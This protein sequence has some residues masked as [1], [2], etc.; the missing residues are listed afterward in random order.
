MLV[1]EMLSEVRDHGFDDL[2]DTRI[3]GFINDTYW[4][5]CSREAWPFLE[6]SAAVTVDATGKITSPASIDK[7]LAISTTSPN[8]PNLIPMRT[9]EFTRTYGTNLSLAGTPQLYYSEGDDFFVYPIPASAQLTIRYIRIP[10]ALTVSPDS[11]P[12]LPIQH[13]RAVVLGTLVK[14]YTLEDDPEQA[15]VFTNMYEQRLVQMR[16]S[17][18]MRQY[19][20]T[21]TIQDLETD[22]ADY[23]ISGSF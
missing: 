21:D 10:D 1:S 19:D 7:V 8:G 12:I 18:W 16:N 2:T 6:A 22:E 3:L 23:W 13:H 14:C 15:G 5:I 17:L 20:R 4:D 11:S 9:D